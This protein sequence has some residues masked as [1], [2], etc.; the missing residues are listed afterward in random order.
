MESPLGTVFT[1]Q[2]K[3][4]AMTMLMSHKKNGNYIHTYLMLVCNNTV[5]SDKTQLLHNKSFQMC[6]TLHI[7]LRTGLCRCKTRSA[8]PEGLPKAP[9]S[10]QFLRKHLVFADIAVRDGATGKPHGLF[11]MLFT[12]LRYLVFLH[13]LV[14]R[15]EAF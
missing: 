12:D 15:E 1:R 2:N 4:Y 9:S 5:M 3:C 7:L 6:Q 14:R 8:L 10:L 11:K 13:V